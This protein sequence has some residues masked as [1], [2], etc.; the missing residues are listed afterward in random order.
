MQKGRFNDRPH[1][2]AEPSLKGQR[3]S[4]LGTICHLPRQLYAEARQQQ[5]LRRRPL[6]FCISW[7]AEARF[8][9]R[10]VEEW[11]AQLEAVRH[12]HEIGIA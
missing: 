4:A 6:Q 5:A 7:N 11:D 1:L 12:A 3:K 2:A 10:T 8:Y 9:K